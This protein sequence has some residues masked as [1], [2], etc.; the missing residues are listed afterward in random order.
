MKVENREKYGGEKKRVDDPEYHQDG[1]RGLQAR[2]QHGD[3][4]APDADHPNKTDV[5]GRTAP[6]DPEYQRYIEYRHDNAAQHSNHLNCP[7]K[8]YRF[9]SF[10]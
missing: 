7:H 8:L 10:L 3:D 4:T 5:S 9:G 6:D 1:I 2:R